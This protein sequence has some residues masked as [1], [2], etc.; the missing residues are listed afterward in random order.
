M[1]TQIIAGWSKGHWTAQDRA[2]AKELMPY[3]WGYKFGS[4][5]RDEATVVIR[6]VTLHKKFLHDCMVDGISVMLD[7]KHCEAAGALKTISNNLRL[8][9]TSLITVDSNMSEEAI[10]HMAR[11]CHAVGSKLLVITVK[12]DQTN[13]D[14][15]AVFGINAF[16]TALRLAR[17]AKRLGADGIVVPGRILAFLR[18]MARELFEENFIAVVAGIRW[19]GQNSGGHVWSIAPHELGWIEPDFVVADSALWQAPGMVPL[20]AASK[21]RNIFQAAPIL[22]R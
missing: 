6:S 12:T 1:P 3:I 22:T 13:E 21:M 16:D 9:L 19:P 14:C 8:D 17:R 11:Q 4:E 7:D 20:E 10:K 5:T 15:E 18:D 2:Q